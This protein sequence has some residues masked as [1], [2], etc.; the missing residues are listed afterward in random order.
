MPESSSTANSIPRL[1]FWQT[2]VSHAITLHPSSIAVHEPCAL[3]YFASGK[4]LAYLTGDPGPTRRRQAGRVRGCKKR[5]LARPAWCLRS[6]PTRSKVKNV[7]VVALCLG[8]CPD[9]DIAATTP[10]GVSTAEP[11]FQDDHQHRQGLGRQTKQQQT[12]MSSCARRK[13]M[14]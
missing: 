2:I 11:R 10:L 9:Y 5:G 13:G 8:I 4:I 12:V 3:G 1:Y 7:H 6:T 14:A